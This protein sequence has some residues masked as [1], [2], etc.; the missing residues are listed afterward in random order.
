MSQLKKYD[1][2]NEILD[3]KE[4]YKIQYI[5]KYLLLSNSTIKDL[6]QLE[7]KID[8]IIADTE[9][10]RKCSDDNIEFIEDINILQREIKAVIAN[11]EVESGLDWF[12]IYLVILILIFFISGTLLCVNG[13]DANELFNRNIRLCTNIFGLFIR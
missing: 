1:F 4:F 12:T 9:T 2:I 5:D 7:E 13:F 6:R 10:T 11:E 8:K 3:R